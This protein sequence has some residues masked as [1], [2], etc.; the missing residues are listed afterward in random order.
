MH[1]KLE[2]F[3]L[4]K[5]QA[6]LQA[7]EENSY[8]FA[9]FE[10]G[11]GWFLIVD[12]LLTSIAD[13]IEHRLKWKPEQYKELQNFRVEQIKEKFGSLRVYT[14]ADNPEI[15]AYTDMASN[16][17]SRTCELCGNPGMIRNEFWLTCKCEECFLRGEANAARLARVPDRMLALILRKD[18]Q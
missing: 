16:I 8:P 17:S 3:L 5:H 18:L 12:E 10:C 7:K 2:E 6:L 11:D 14:M 13:Y 1:T 4:K 15:E 9:G